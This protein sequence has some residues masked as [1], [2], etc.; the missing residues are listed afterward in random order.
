MYTKVLR[1]TFVCFLLKE[2]ELGT[3]FELGIVG[4]LGTL[5]TQDQGRLSALKIGRIMMILHSG[6]HINILNASV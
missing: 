5:G 3:E 6:I 2:F 4:A 1:I